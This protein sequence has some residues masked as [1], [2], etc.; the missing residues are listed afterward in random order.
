MQEPWGGF[1]FDCAARLLLKTG[2]LNLPLLLKRQFFFAELHRHSCYVLAGSFNGFLIRRYGWQKY[3][4]LFRT[5]DGLGFPKKVYKCFGV[6]LEEAERQ[7][8]N[9]IFNQ[10]T[11]NPL[12]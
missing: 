7:G 12:L 6:T 5:C 10:G 2:N 3:Y 8:R 4:K 1:P 9:E 11:L